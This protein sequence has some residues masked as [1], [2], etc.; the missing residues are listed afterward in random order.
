MAFVVLI[1]SEGFDFMQHIHR[2][3][4]MRTTNLLDLMRDSQGRC[5]TN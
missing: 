5:S 1:F 4:A 2:V 3:Y